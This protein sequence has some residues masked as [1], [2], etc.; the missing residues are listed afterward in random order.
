MIADGFIRTG[1]HLFKIGDRWV[2]IY[3][4]VRGL[5]DANR[6][7]WNNRGEAGLGVRILPFE[8]VGLVLFAEG[9]RGDFSG[10]AGRDPNPNEEP[11]WDV[12]G[13]FALWQWGGTEPWEV[14]TVDFSLPFTGWREVYAEGVYFDR[15][16]ENFI[17]SVHYKEGLL[18][19]RAGRFVYDAYL[20]LEAGTDENALYWNNYVRGGPGFRITPWDGLDMKI[21]FEY[22]V[23]EYYRGD[24]RRVEEE[25]SDV[26][27]AL[28]FYWE[29]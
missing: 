22:V 6:D 17:G 4:K 7:Y 9:L 11:Y 20:S 1:V 18:L 25:F 12:Q 28:S 19:G 13:G 24:L 2:D 26:I 23:G 15:N 21:R 5:Y 14:E 29:N 8:K 27:V 3:L 10:R 16:D